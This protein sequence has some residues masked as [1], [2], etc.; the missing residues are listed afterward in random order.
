[1]AV[2]GREINSVMR[3]ACEQ[4]GL[5]VVASDTDSV[6]VV[7][8]KD[9]TEE[10]YYDLARYLELCIRER[11]GVDITVEP[12]KLFS[13]IYFPRR[14]GDST[15]AKKKY[16]G[17]VAWRK[18][19]GRITPTV[20]TVG[21]E[22]VRSDWPQAIKDLQ[23]LVVSEYLTG[24]KVTPLVSEFVSMLRKGQIPVEQLALSKSISKADTRLSHTTSKRPRKQRS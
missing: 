14:G 2:Y 15:A 23:K 1:V 4:L 8:P 17:L 3:E 19:K 6:F 20:E 10:G 24:G 9:T 13:R 22:S 18:G 7:I 21:M 11:M 5:K 16:A 12:D